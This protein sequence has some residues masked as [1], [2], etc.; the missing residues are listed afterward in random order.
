[1]MSSY[2]IDNLLGFNCFLLYTKE[3]TFVASHPRDNS[4]YEL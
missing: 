1:M 3:K 4:V 2:C